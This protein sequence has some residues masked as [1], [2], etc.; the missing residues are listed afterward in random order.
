MEKTS[1]SIEIV[2]DG[3]SY[4]GWATPSDRLHPDGHAKSYHV[5]LNDV[6]WGNLSSNKGKWTISEQRPHKL[7]EAVG[8]AIEEAEATRSML[9]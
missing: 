9:N 8:Q 1:L 4:I 6:F 5:V 7:V 2:H 3:Q